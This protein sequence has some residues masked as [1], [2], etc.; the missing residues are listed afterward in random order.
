MLLDQ[1]NQFISCE[2]PYKANFIEVLGSKMH[3]VDEGE[4]DPIV[5][6]HGI[7]TWSYLWRNII[8][9]LSKSARCIAPDLIGLGKSEKPN[10][11]YRIFDHIRYITEFID[12]LGL[13]NITF[14]VHGWGSIIGFEYARQHEQNI[15]GL[16]FLESH[17][18]PVTD[19][20]MV[21]LPV[22]ELSTVLNTP[23]GG[24]DVIMNSNYFVNKVLP[25]GVLRKL[26]EEEL[27]HYREPFMKTGSCKPLWQYLKDLPLGNGPNDVVE[28]IANYSQ[29]L[30]LTNLPKLMLYAV[31]GFITTISTVQWARDHLS[32]L[33]LVDVGDALHYAQETKPDVIGE[34]INNWYKSLK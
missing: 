7:P 34:E 18:R 19:W 32:K 25:S 14:V 27:Q 31:P 23:D 26:T 6:L 2:F 24:Y 5:F 17:I 20:S 3:Y 21:S 9:F 30:Q 1:E 15:K 16:A 8:P 13:K 33:I 4:G 10:I 22:Q 12:K 29:W 11:A 28:L